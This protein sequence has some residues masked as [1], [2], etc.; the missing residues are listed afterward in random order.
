[1]ADQFWGTGGSDVADGLT[2]A[3]AR[4]N[5]S[6][7]VTNS[8]AGDSVIAID[9]TMIHPTSLF[10]YNDDRIESSETYRRATLK[11]A[12]SET[13][14]VARTSALLAV[15]NPFLVDGLVFDGDNGGANTVNNAFALFRQSTVELIYQL[16]NC[17]FICGDIAALKQD[18]RRGRTEIVNGKISG[19]LSSILFGLSGS[20]GVNL[21]Q[22]G[23]QVIDVQILDIQLDAPITGSKIGIQLQQEDVLGSPNTLDV[24]LKGV[25]GV[26][27]IGAS[28]SVTL[29]DIKSNST[30]SCASGDITINADDAVSNVIGISVRG[31][32]VT[33][34]I[35]DINIT[36]QRIKFNSPAGHGIAFGSDTDS[37]ISG[38]LVSGNHVTGKHYTS[39]SPHN[40]S[41]RHSI[42]GAA[43]GNISQDGYIGYLMAVCTNATVTAN[44]AYDCYG[45]SYYIKGTTAALVKDNVAVV[46]TKF[47]QRDL[48]ILA[49]APQGATNT[50]AATIQENLVIVT[51][52]SNIHSLGYIED[53]N[54]V[55]SFVRNTYII[56]DTVDVSSAL[57]FSYENGAGGAANNTLAQ[58][59]AQTEVTDDIIVQMPQAELDALSESLRPIA[60]GFPKNNIVSSFIN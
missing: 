23:N 58:W 27:P 51:D 18:Q 59:N 46:T 25:S 21:A 48:G 19:T 35:S 54:Q 24:Y 14:Y 11:A 31:R 2:P 41:L 3:T 16:H 57:L 52:I 39:A 28:A 50:V 15:N 55:C 47:P 43:R 45:S 22:D 42:V 7:A 5:R 4:L 20:G 40:I 8:G 26:I 30:I 36:N 56:P 6:V 1:M 10:L 13:E 37:F 60:G 12:V 34:K 9:G 17:E 29:I 33:D 53:V 49:V 38:G 44:L 32:L